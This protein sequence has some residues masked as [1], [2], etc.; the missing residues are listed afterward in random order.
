MKTLG[1][2]DAAAREAA[3]KRS[4]LRSG[5]YGALVQDAA[6]GV[7]ARGNDMIVA[8]V[9]VANASGDER[10]IKDYLT[11]AASFAVKLRN[12]CAAVGALDKYAAGEISASDFPGHAVRVRVG[13]E[14]KRGYPDRNIIED[15]AAAD[16]PNRVVTLRGAV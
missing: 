13:I 7:S 11:S 15:Y 12:A 8:T 9:I 6:E 16:E 5:W 2:S 10:T 1:L 14:K 4:L 3:R